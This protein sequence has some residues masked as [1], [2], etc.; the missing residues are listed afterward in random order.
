[1][2]YY[3]SLYERR[4]ANKVSLINFIDYIHQLVDK[5]VGEGNE[6]KCGETSESSIQNYELQSY[7]ELRGTADSRDNYLLVQPCEPPL[8]RHT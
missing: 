1:M 2:L 8:S 5:K 6:V 4:Y 3:T 7:I